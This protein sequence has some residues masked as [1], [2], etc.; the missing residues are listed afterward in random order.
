MRR[1]AAPR[2][3]LRLQVQPSEFRMDADQC[4]DVVQLSDI[5]SR[6]GSLFG[7]RQALRRRQASFASPQG[8]CRWGK[9]PEVGY[10]ELVRGHPSRLDR[11]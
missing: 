4:S 6:I 3:V 7:L 11:L 9:K 10:G 1:T 8:L 5:E 2:P